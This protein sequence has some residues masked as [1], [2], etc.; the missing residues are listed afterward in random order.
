MNHTGIQLNYW[1]RPQQQRTYLPG[2]VNVST[3]G[4]G[5]ICLSNEREE[6]IP[7]YMRQGKLYEEDCDY[8]IP[9]LI[10]A[11]ELRAKYGEKTLPGF[12]EGFTVEKFIEGA[13]RTLRNWH[14]D[15]Y[16]RYFGET[17][18]PGESYIKDKTLD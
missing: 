8:A 10:F 14:P 3:A 7:E 16:E 1:G 11:E 15:A 4:H 18:S 9:V 5:G 12:C 13:K 6:M 2:V 17:I